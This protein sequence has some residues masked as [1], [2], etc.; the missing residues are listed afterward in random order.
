MHSDRI[1]VERTE[2]AFSVFIEAYPM[3][4]FAFP[5]F[6]VKSPIAGVYARGTETFRM[7]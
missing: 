4:H 7:V 3:R 6:K 1:A 5:N 2:A